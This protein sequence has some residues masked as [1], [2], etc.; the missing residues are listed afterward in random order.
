M[1]GFVQAAAHAYDGDGVGL[2]SV[3]CGG[4]E[5]EVGGGQTEIF[6]REVH[7][8]Q[9]VFGWREMDRTQPETTRLGSPPRQHFAVASSYFT[10]PLRG[11]APAAGKVFL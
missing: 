7:V 8:A 10:S 9:V 5:G 6:W 3:V 2:M 11:L 1:T 4:G